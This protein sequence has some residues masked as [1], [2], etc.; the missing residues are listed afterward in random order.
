MANQFFAM[1]NI[2]EILE[3]LRSLDPDF[4]I[5]PS[6][7]YQRIMLGDRLWDRLLERD[8]C[9]A[10]VVKE[11]GFWVA[12]VTIGKSTAIAFDLAPVDALLSAYVRVL[13]GESSN[14]F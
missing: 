2:G 9:E 13:E 6:T 5:P 1:D 12:K 11:K 8:D 4:S 14:V 7:A 3:R 10:Q